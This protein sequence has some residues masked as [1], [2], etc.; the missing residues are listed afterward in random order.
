M[1]SLLIPLVVFYYFKINES[2]TWHTTEL[3][4]AFEGLKKPPT[5]AL[6]HYIESCLLRFSKIW[7]DKEIK[8]ILFAH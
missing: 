7:G 3:L 6:N 4:M 8:Y 2:Y 1:Q 5:T